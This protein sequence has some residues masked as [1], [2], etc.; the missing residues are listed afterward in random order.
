M[1]LSILEDVATQKISVKDISDKAMQERKK[2]DIRKSFVTLTNMTSWEE[3][4]DKFPQET[5]EDNLMQFK[6]LNFKK[7]IP[8]VNIKLCGMVHGRL[9]RKSIAHILDVCTLP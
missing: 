4:V 7:E 9:Q 2:L 8:Q 1:K 3:A 6:E 5:S